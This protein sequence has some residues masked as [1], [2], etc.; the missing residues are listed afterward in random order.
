MTVTAIKGAKAGQDKP[1]KPSIAKD[2]VASTSTAKILYIL[3]EGEI[4]GLVD[5]GK[6]IYLDGTP[7]LD[8]VGNSNFEGVTWDFRHGTNE[9]E[10]I[11]GFP[12][13]GRASCRERV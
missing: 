1:R 12:E 2:S 10:Y 4:A 7:L 6:S 3:G 11:K 13:I 5:G 8:D 9:Q